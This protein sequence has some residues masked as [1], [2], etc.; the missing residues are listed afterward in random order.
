[1]KYGDKALKIYKQNFPEKAFETSYG[2][3]A[4]LNLVTGKTCVLNKLVCTLYSK[5]SH[6][7][8]NSNPSM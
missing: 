1:L 8:I 4:N 5:V 6:T 3:S 7:V 2:T